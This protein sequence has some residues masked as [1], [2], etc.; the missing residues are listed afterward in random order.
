MKKN[1][2]IAIVII[3]MIFI[4]IMSSFDSGKS[5]SQSNFIVNIIT[6]L[7]NIENTTL[8]I[9]IVR[10]LAN[11]TEYF[12]LGLLMYNLFKEKNKAFNISLFN[13]ILYAIFDEIHQ[14]FVAGRTCKLLDI[15]IDALGSF[16]GI[17]IF[18]TFKKMIHK[19]L[20]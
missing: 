15:G 11:F 9:L 7:F 18:I 2:N 13:C 4:F 14:L 12:I 20:M 17:I 16:V 8:L 19:K 3:W 1:I 6:Y 10:K 5:A